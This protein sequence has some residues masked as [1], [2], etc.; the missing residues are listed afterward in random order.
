MS[1]LQ[2]ILSIPAALG[3]VVA[4]WFADFGLLSWLGTRRLAS[5]ALQFVAENGVVCPA[6]WCA[7]HFP[8]PLLLAPAPP[9]ATAAAGVPDPPR[10][11][12]THTC[13]H[14]HLHLIAPPQCCIAPQDTA[15]PLN[16]RRTPGSKSMKAG[17]EASQEY[18]ASLEDEDFAAKLTPISSPAGAPGTPQL[19]AL[20]R[21]TRA[22]PVSVGGR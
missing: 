1:A 8:T 12:Q 11:P 15:S 18:F 22:A 14:P 13:P 19:H 17:P 10:R 5:Q 9:L 6:G 3:I 4:W 20:P 21:A 7:A 2:S 16:F